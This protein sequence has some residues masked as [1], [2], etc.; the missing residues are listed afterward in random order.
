MS[1]YIL[2]FYIFLTENQRSRGWGHWEQ[3]RFDEPVIL[4]ALNLEPSEAL[5]TS[6]ATETLGVFESLFLNNMTSCLDMITSF[7]DS[8]GYKD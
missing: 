6:L 4:I 8:R 5:Q 7:L 3:L 1:I 2:D